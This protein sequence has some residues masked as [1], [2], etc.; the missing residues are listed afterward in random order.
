MRRG[1]R[2]LGVVVVLSLASVCFAGF[3]RGFTAVE[4][5]NPVS[6]QL[7]V[8]VS[9]AG[10]GAVQFTF[11]NRTG[12]PSSTN[13]IFFDQNDGIANTLNFSGA[14]PALRIESGRTSPSFV[15]D[16]QPAVL[17]GG[18]SLASPFEADFSISAL[19]STQGLNESGDA[20][21]VTAPLGVGR[22]FQDVLNALAAGD[23]RLGLR[24][25]GS[26]GGGLMDLG[27]PQTSVSANWSES[28]VSVVVPAPDA[29]A[30]GLLGVGLVG[31]LGRRR[32]A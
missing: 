3:D 21:H 29:A 23:L 5:V 28:F 12:L 13:Q 18:H 15:I 19:S 24:V 31:A 20:L 17:P 2:V 10:A 7:W 25:V 4:G 14:L 9:E 32:F 11:Q 6:G 30:L 16:R 8:T 1:R 26:S 22:T 27:A